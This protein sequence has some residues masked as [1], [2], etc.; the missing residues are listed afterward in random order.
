MGMKAQVEDTIG[1]WWQ[2]L[3]VLIALIGM[4]IFI[5]QGRGGLDQLMRGLCERYPSI[6][7]CG[8]AVSLPEGDTKTAE[9]AAQ[10]LVCAVNTVANGAEWKGE[11]GVDCKKFTYVSDSS[12]EYTADFETVTKRMKGV[13]STDEECRAS[14]KAIC[15]DI[16]FCKVFEDKVTAD[17]TAGVCV[18]PAR[19]PKTPFLRCDD[20]DWRSCEIYNFRLPQNVPDTAYNYI[21]DHG[22]PNFLVYWQSFPMEWDT[23]SYRSDWEMIAGIVVLS[24]LPPFKIAGALGR[25]GISAAKTLTKEGAE[26]LIVKEFGATLGKSMIKN[27]GLSYATKKAVRS[28]LTKN[29][30]EVIKRRLL[31]RTGRVFVRGAVLSGV[32]LAKEQ[33][34]SMLNKYNVHGNSIVLKR[35]YMQ[36]QVFQLSDGVKGKPVVIS[37]KPGLLTS[38]RHVN[39]HLVSPCQ[40]KKLVARSATVWC[41]EYYF[42][43][44]DNTAICADLKEDSAGGDNCD[45][46][47]YLGI[48]DKYVSSIEEIRKMA[49]QEEIGKLKEMQKTTNIVIEEWNFTENIKE[50]YAK[51]ENAV[52]GKWESLTSVEPWKIRINYNGKSLILSDDN[53]DSKY[54]SYGLGECKKEA[55]IV[56]LDT[57]SGNLQKMSDEYNYC[58]DNRGTS[59]YI[60][61]WAGIGIGSVGVIAARFIPGPAWVAGVLVLASVSTGTAIEASSIYQKWVGQWPGGKG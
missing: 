52:E 9:Q 38:T 32:S 34:E 17:K 21:V 45:I 10:A 3:L 15:N 43:A 36:E 60:G 41:R 59:D 28:I 42:N 11:G 57:G 54:E 20:P 14:C 46:S 51:D 1:E 30:A 23:W 26:S 33:A 53:D 48:D 16:P 5:T 61:E 58:V 56:D 39:A 44:F 25:T 13:G 31:D 22:D 12:T 24:I 47:A 4:V 19:I 50:S 55:V 27:G 29:L 18:C 8:T 2:I 35:P 6:P 7:F 37:W 40:A 49:I